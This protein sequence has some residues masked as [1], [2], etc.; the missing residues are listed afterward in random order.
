MTVQFLI[1][2]TVAAA[3][4]A[5]SLRGFES[6]TVRTPPTKARITCRASFVP[7]LLDAISDIAQGARGELLVDCGVA[8]AAGLEAIRINPGDEPAD[9]RS[10]KER[11]LLGL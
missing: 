11:G 5:S 3:L 10:D 1:P 4:A 6:S 7:A 2:K 9:Q 8:T